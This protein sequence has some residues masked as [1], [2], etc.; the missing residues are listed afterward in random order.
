MKLLCTFSSEVNTGTLQLET[1]N[2]ISGG[3]VINT[4]MLSNGVRIG[5]LDQL[6]GKWNF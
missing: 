3:L 1:M 2:V 4:C 6:N 5:A